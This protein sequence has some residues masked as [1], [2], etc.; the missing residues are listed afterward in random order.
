MV[1]SVYFSYNRVERPAR[2]EQRSPFRGPDTRLQ[3]FNWQMVIGH[4][5]THGYSRIRRLT[6]SGSR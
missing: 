5:D 3:L 2:E 4:A 6:G 1:Y